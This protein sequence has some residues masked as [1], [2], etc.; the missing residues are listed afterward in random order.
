MSETPTTVVVWGDSIAAG[1]AEYQ[2]PAIA[3]RTCNLVLNTGTPVRVVN[4]GVGGKPACH[5]RHEFEER[6]LAHKPALAIIQFGF[7]DMRYDGSRGDQPLSTPAEFEEHL[8]VMVRRC[9]EEAQARV[10]LFGNHRTQLNLLMP[11]GKSYDE[12]RVEYDGAVRRVAAAMDVP[13]YDLSEELKV[14]GASWTEFLVADGVHL[15]PLGYH[16]YGRF[17]A[18]VMMRMLV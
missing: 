6:V 16:A 5:A 7:N 4:K 8:Q 12:T 14:P 13:Y 11:T 2:W 9:R 15:S 18:N 3:E 1:S 17:A 10:V